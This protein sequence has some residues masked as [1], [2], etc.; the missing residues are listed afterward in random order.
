MIQNKSMGF[1]TKANFLVTDPPP[2]TRPR[3]AFASKNC[4]FH[5]ESRPNPDQF[6]QKNLKIDRSLEKR[7]QLE[8]LVLHLLKLIFVAFDD[9]L[10]RH[11]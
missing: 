5:T 9:Q 11:H 4:T 1:D 6:P 2:F 10:L 7:T 8:G 3:G